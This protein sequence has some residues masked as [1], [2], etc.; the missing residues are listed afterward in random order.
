[1][2]GVDFDMDGQYLLIV[3]FSSGQIEARKHRTGDLVHSTKMSSSIVELFYHDYRQEGI[4]QVIAVDAEGDVK[5]L[6]LTRNVR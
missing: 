5:G 2:L 3:G 6:S 1:M 4:P